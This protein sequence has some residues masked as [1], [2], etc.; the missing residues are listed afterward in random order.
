MDNLEPIHKLN[1][2]LKKAAATLTANEARFLVDAYYIMQRDRIRSGHQQRTLEEAGEPNQLLGWF[3]DNTGVLERNIKGA[4]GVYSQHSVVGRWAECA[5]PG[6][7]VLVESGR[8]SKGR[9]V[10]IESLRSGDVVAPFDRRRARLGSPCSIA[11]NSTQYDGLLMQV[12]TADYKTEVT[13]A[14]K[15]L[16]K[17]TEP[18]SAFIVYLMRRGPWFRVGVTKALYPRSESAGRFGLRRRV[19]QEGADEAWVLK[20]CSSRREAFVYEAIIAAK[21]GLSTTV[22]NGRDGYWSVTEV[23]QL[24]AALDVVEQGDRAARCLADHGLEF[25]TPMLTDVGFGTKETVD[26]VVSYAINL[27]PEL[28]SLPVP[29]R[30]GGIEWQPIR[31]VTRRLYR[32]PVYSLDVSEHH[33]YVQD[34]LATCNSIIGIGPVISAGL[35]AHIDLEPWRCQRIRKE[36]PFYDPKLKKACTSKEPCGAE[37]QTQVVATAGP[38]WRFAGLDPTVVWREK[39]KRPWNGALKRLCWIIGESFMKQSGHEHDF[40]GKLYLHRKAQEIDRNCAGQNVAQAQTAL[41]QKKWGKDTDA[42]IWYSGRLTPDAAKV[43]W[44]TPAEKRLGLAK[45]L[46]GEVGTGV[47]MLPPARIQ[48]RA[49]RYAVKLFLSHWHCVAFYHK[50]GKMPPKPY[51]I[52][53]LGHANM[54]QV[55]EWPFPDAK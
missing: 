51:V 24:Y 17:F 34:G 11:V 46:A 48:L 37:C 2:D 13:P 31:K 5:P 3:F 36:S 26:G 35:L 16:V 7:Q 32:G 12:E 39:E 40:Y 54:I 49:Q 6:S 29:L 20:F 9:T 14:H 27:V 52:E 33:K 22:F 19:R 44:N 42:L 4:L 8:W 15:W 21:Y 47:Q 30:G 55:P 28:M 53:H 41:A 50:Y 23:A 38:I 18:E 43:W 1:R 45:K 10:P 25:D